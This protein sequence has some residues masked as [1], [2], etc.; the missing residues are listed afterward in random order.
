MIAGN[1]SDVAF[2]D[3]LQFLH[4]SG[5]S[6]TLYLERPEDT[7]CISFH[8]GRI[9]SAWCQSATTVVQHLQQAGQLR[10]ED[11]VRARAMHAG[12][13]AGRTLGQVLLSIAAIEQG[14]LRAAV[15]RKIEETVLDL[16]GWRRGSFRFVVEEVRYDEELLFAP[17]D[18]VR[19]VDLDTQMV[20]MEALRLFDERGRESRPSLTAAAARV[21]AQVEREEA[22]R[23]AAVKAAAPAPVEAF[24]ESV[25]A[26]RR[27]GDATGAIGAVALIGDDAAL[28]ASARPALE[29]LGTVTVLGWHDA[30][31]LEVS[32][33]VCDARAPGGLAALL[34]L[35]RRRRGPIVAVVGELGAVGAAYGAGAQA[36]TSAEPTAIAACCAG[37]LAAARAAP[38]AAAAP[39]LR[40][41]LAGLH[42]LTQDIRAGMAA[43]RLSTNLMA[44]FARAADRG[45]LFAARRDA[46]VALT[47]F[48]RTADRALLSD[49][50]R[51]LRL[52]LERDGQFAAAL[53]RGHAE[54]FTWGD[55][56]T[57]TRLREVLGPPATRTGLLL[58][59]MGTRRGIAVIYADNGD[60][61]E[62][63]ADVE[64][65]DI[66]TSQFGLAIDNEI[67]RR[68]IDR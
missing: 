55:D 52:P 54:T 18:V 58:P 44:V 1:L 13:E 61:P 17:H 60:D 7:A 63:I 23:A 49:A 22:A 38:A 48:G 40:S 36:V 31:A 24:D 37:V 59:V 19:K 43:S 50:T 28:L 4:M 2:P 42:G 10:A 68:Q 53:A 35:R 67:L 39:S 21:V 57:T 65:L 66:A 6:G 3:L 62:P 5:R 30:A 51:G 33:V 11:V 56:L 16:V 26:V 20:L 9:A 14:E 47:A 32:L 29:A 12:D 15:A 34:E 41:A 25:T 46:L 45:V 64:L 27:R 8:D